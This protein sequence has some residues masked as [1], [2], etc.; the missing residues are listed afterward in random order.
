MVQAKFLDLLYNAASHLNWGCCNIIKNG[1]T[2]KDND[3]LN[4]KKAQL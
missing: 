2:D 3:T 1:K 4:L